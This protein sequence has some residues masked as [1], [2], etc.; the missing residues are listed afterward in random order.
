MEVVISFLNFGLVFLFGV[1]A[2][3]L[4]QLQ[5]AHSFLKTQ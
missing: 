1:A 3:P 4:V 5:D 2:K